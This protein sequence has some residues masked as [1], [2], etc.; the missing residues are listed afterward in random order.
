ME[1]K[2]NHEIPL[3]TFQ[4]KVKLNCYMCISGTNPFFVTK[5]NLSFLIT[6]SN[7]IKIKLA[8]FFKFLMMISE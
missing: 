8:H 5:Y 2:N 4:I 3:Y 6:K 7:E 1:R